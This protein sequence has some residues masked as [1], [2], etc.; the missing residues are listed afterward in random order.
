[1]LRGCLSGDKII[2]TIILNKVFSEL[3]KVEVS[4]Q[5][6]II[7]DPS[8][9]SYY[10]PHKQSGIPLVERKEERVRERE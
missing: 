6:I 5:L 10:T 8:I 3:F 2:W 1:M 7:G 9:Q 4:I